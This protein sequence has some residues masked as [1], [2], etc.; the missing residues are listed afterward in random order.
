MAP[1]NPVVRKTLVDQVCSLIR[2]RILNFELKPGEKI[3][4][5]KLA[6]ELSVSQTP[7]REALQKLA[8]QGLV[9]S[10]PYV[11]YFVIELT[12][13]D[14]EELFDLRRALEVLAVEYIIKKNCID[15]EHLAHLRKWIA[16]L[17]SASDEELVSEVQRMDEKLH[18]DL[19]IRG[20]QSQWLT[21]FANGII[22]L[23]KLT[24]RLTMNPRAACR[25]HR[26]IIEALAAKDLER[27]VSALT[28]HLERAKKEAIS[29]LKGGENAAKTDSENT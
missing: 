17:R 15:R 29:A 4:V 23:I 9:V 12:P 19:L 6:Q 5:Q 3:E 16:E 18:L 10:K 14:V 21:K 2:E 28:A 1:K 25:E 13:T 7:L 27:A 24:T 22:D 26:E 8:E 20:S 11:G